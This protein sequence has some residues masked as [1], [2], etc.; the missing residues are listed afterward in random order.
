MGGL[1]VWKYGRT[2][3]REIVILLGTKKTNYGG[4]AWVGLFAWL[5]E[6]IDLARLP[7]VL[8]DASHSFHAGA[9]V[10]CL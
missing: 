1:G 2:R 6:V 3:L 7:S 8:S 9:F 4:F 10:V 5:F